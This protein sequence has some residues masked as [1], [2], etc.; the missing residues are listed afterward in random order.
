MLEMLPRLDVLNCFEHGVLFAVGFWQ[1]FPGGLRQTAGR[2]DT[3]AW[4]ARTN[5]LCYRW[6]VRA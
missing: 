5:L 2:S 6:S 4:L 1:E 3:P